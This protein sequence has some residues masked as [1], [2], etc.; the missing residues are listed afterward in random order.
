MEAVEVTTFKLNRG[1]TMADFVEANAD[2]D[3]WLLKQP[4]F[5][6]RRI[7][8]RRDGVVT[9]LLIWASAQVGEEAATRLMVELANSPVHDAI[10]QRSVSWTVSP[11]HHRL[12]R[13]AGYLIGQEPRAEALM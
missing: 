13:V 9:D 2:V 7:S 3:A 1:L 11:I 12:D 8:Q 6:S 4:G 5:I 10:D